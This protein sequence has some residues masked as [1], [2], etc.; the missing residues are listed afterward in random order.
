MIPA[1]RRQKVLEFI[2]ENGSA[3]VSVLSQLFQ[4]SEMTIHRDL[5]FLE[6]HGHVEKKYGG[7]ISSLSKVETAFNIRKMKNADAKQKIGQ[8]AA[9]LVQDG[10]TIFLDASTTCLAMTP[11]LDNHCDLTIFTTGIATASAL[12]NLND[13]NHVFCSGGEISR[14]TLSITG[15]IAVNLLRSIHVDKCFLGG[16]G[17]HPIHGVTDPGIE[18]VEIKKVAASRAKQLI[19]LVDKTKFGKLNRFADFPISEIDLIITD[20]D[21]SDPLVA[22]VEGTGVDILYVRKSS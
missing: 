3:K 15:P 18:E 20:A 22:E 9:E 1:E 5:S 12:I 10:D 4:V 7:V 13:S 19:L 16:A 21:K 17:V 2:H 8:A 14:H 11:A 6:E